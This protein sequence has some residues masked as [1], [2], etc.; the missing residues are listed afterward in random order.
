MHSSCIALIMLYNRKAII[1][2]GV[3]SVHNLLCKGKY[4]ET[5][6]SFEIFYAIDLSN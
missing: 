3:M 5:T 6:G 2:P 4:T 1:C